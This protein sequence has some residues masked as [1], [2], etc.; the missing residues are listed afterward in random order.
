[1]RPHEEQT[2]KP[3]DISAIIKI[4]LDYETP[5]NMPWMDL[6]TPR[7]WVLQDCSPDL[8]CVPTMREIMKKKFGI[9]TYSYFSNAIY[10]ARDKRLTLERINADK[11]KPDC[12]QF[13]QNYKWKRDRGLPLT[14]EQNKILNN[15]L[16]GNTN[17]HA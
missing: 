9:K 3:A 17:V 15:W 12:D 8:D 14:D 2:D 1:M 7:M 11:P 5:Q 16:G 10:A 4:A 13:I 6:N